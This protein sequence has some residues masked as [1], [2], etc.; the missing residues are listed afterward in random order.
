MFITYSFYF[1][2]LSRFF[3]KKKVKKRKNDYLQPWEH[4][5]KQSYSGGAWQAPSPP[6][7][8]PLLHPRTPRKLRGL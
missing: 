1:Y 3:T 4:N 2:G 7:P 6:P 8:P 5:S